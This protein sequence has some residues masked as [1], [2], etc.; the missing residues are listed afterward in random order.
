MDTIDVIAARLVEAALVPAPGCDEVAPQLALVLKQGTGALAPDVLRVATRQ[1]AAQL[2][3]M[4]CS[5]EVLTERLLRIVDVAEA[6]LQLL[7]AAS[8]VPA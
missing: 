4:G 8:P 5:A 6:T 3:L 2:E 1:A 7:R